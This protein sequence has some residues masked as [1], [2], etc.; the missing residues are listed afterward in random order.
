MTA[1]QAAAILRKAPHFDHCDELGRYEYRG[2]GSLA[3]M[4]DAELQRAEYGLYYC[5]YSRSRAS[6]EV[7]GY[8]LSRCADFGPV[9][10]QAAD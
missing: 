9:T 4:P 2:T 6:L 5:D 10:L 1:D 7:L 3:G 8:V